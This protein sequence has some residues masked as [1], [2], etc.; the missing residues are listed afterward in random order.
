MGRDAT[1]LLDDGDKLQLSKSI[2]LVYHSLTP[3]RGV[4]LTSIQQR[5]KQVSKE[6]SF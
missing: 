5:E 2:T 4:A 1:F 3:V 6:T